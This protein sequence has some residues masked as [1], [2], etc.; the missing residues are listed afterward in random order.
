MYGILASDGSIYAHDA[1]SS[2][3]GLFHDE[4]LVRIAMGLWII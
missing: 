1:H 2:D 4:V 3:R